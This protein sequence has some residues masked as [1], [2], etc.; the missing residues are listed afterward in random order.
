MDLQ[1]TSNNIHDLTLFKIEKSLKQY[2][3]QINEIDK[4]IENLKSGIDRL[5]LL[6][7]TIKTAINELEQKVIK[8]VLNIS[9]KITWFNYII[10]KFIYYL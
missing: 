6:K 7:E 3:D 10:I 4:S 8:S 1:Q 2:K 9:F 5:T